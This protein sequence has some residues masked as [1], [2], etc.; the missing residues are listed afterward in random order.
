MT[1]PDAPL[2][3]ATWRREIA[4]LYADI[5]TTPAADEPVAWEHWRDRRRELFAEHPQSP[6]GP[7][8]RESFNGLQYYDYD[9]VYRVEATVA[10]ETGGET[11]TVEVADGVL[12]YRQVG[13][14]K[15][16]LRGQ[17]CQLPLYWVTGYGGGLFLPFGDE[18]NGKRTFGGG[19]Y[20]YDTIKGADLGAGPG[21]TLPLDFNYAYNPS[22]AYDDRWECP[23]A[24]AQSDLSMLIEAGEHAFSNPT[25]EASE[26]SDAEHQASAGPLG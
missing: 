22:C 21:D 26:V 10:A 17:S 20:L 9:P 16:T 5:R 18:T 2:A 11:F 6:L 3:L 14:A 13:T 1:L 8:A 7:S 15:F 4:E 25:A 23:L 19:R 24:P 12:Q